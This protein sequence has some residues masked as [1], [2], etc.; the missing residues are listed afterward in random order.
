[1]VSRWGEQDAEDVAMIATITCFIL[2][3]ATVVD[4]QTSAV[5]IIAFVTSR[6]PCC[7]P[8]TFICQGLVV[9]VQLAV[10]FMKVYDR[11]QVLLVWCLLWCNTGILEGKN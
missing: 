11:V 8:V 2:S 10:V 6:R 3:I 7:P 4:I 1:M 5:S 9:T